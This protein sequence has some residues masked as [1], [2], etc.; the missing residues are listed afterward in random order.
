[1]QINSIDVIY[2]VL[3]VNAAAATLGLT[4]TAFTNSFAPVVTNLVALGANGLPT[5][6]GAQ[7]QVTNVAVPSP[8]MIVPVLDTQILLNINLT[9]GAGGTVNF[10]GA[11]LKCSFNFN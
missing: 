1:M 4:K 9:A 8:V 3:A 10:Y 11:V 2:Q 7:P 6:I 5:V